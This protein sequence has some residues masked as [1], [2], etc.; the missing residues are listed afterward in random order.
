MLAF[1][2]HNLLCMLIMAKNPI[3]VVESD[4][5]DIELIKMAVKQLKIDRPVVYLHTADQLE[6][7]LNTHGAPPFFILCDVNLP[8]QNGFELHKHIA[9]KTDLKYKSVPFIFWSNVASEQQIQQ[10]YDLPAQ[11][12]FIKPSNFDELCTEFEII[13]NYWQQSK[14]PKRV[15]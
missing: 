12:F 8:G 10:A 5:D 1:G 14:H 11:G 2:W 15:V 9:E 7:Y 6:Q 3:L 13:V 4:D